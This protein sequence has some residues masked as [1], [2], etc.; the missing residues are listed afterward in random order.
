MSA[1]LEITERTADM[2]TSSK[3][4]IV[5]STWAGRTGANSAEKVKSERVP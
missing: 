3:T 5:I 1:D 2:K 4:E